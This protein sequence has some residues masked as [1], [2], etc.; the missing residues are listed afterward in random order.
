MRVRTTRCRRGRSG[1]PQISRAGRR[2]PRRRDPLSAGCGEDG[3]PEAESRFHERAGPWRRGNGAGAAPS[4]PRK[5]GPVESPTRCPYDN[6]GRSASAVASRR[7]R[8]S[9][10]SEAAAR[11][12]RAIL[13]DRHGWSSRSRSAVASL[14]VVHTS[15]LVGVGRG[16]PA[17]VGMRQS[18]PPIATRNT[19]RRDAWASTRLVEVGRATA[20]C[21]EQAIGP[22][23]AGAL[24][25]GEP[26][27]WW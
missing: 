16:A 7:E 18:A 20:G 2:L 11:Q 27:K 9:S 13:L 23:S 4:L 15:H 25:I 19:D 12:R 17:S 14:G 21:D 8:G 5:A 6:E 1:V 3:R 24:R 10:T 26:F 22:A